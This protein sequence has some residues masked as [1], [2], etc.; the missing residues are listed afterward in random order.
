MVIWQAR[1]LNATCPDRVLNVHVVGESIDNGDVHQI[2]LPHT[3]A[4]GPV[5][6]EDYGLDLA[7]RFLP[8]RV[9][10]NA[11]QVNRF[12]HNRS[13]K[14]A[15]GPTTKAQ[16]QNKLIL[17]L[18]DLLLQALNST[19]D[20]SALMSYLKKLITEFTI[21]MNLDAEDETVQRDD[22]G[23]VQAQFPALE[24]PSD[25]EFQQ[26]KKKGDEAER[27]VMHASLVKSREKK[28]SFSDNVDQWMDTAQSPKRYRVGDT[29]DVATTSRPSPINRSSLIEEL[30]KATRTL[31][32]KAQTP[33]SLSPTT[34]GDLEI[35][36]RTPSAFS[37]FTNGE[38]HQGIET[39]SFDENDY[40]D[41]GPDTHTQDGTAEHGL[42]SSV[43]DHSGS[44]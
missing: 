9:I 34:A 22:D 10:K 6:N 18:P 36:A 14:K 38:R 3:V 8:E 30:K 31:T 17:A 13:C 29:P 21:R 20:D 7:R 4:S 33:R 2:T 42:S 37:D 35:L 5:R 25:E 12:L 40:D 26:W 39:I 27:R 11:E 44:V 32:E 1:I 43:G 24:K 16:R 23:Q 15:F 41:G 28:R 19:M